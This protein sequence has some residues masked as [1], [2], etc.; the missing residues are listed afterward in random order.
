MCIRCMIEAVLIKMSI[1]QVSNSERV[2]MK[3]ALVNTEQRII[4]EVIDCGC[5]VGQDT[6][7]HIRLHVIGEG[8]NISCSS[9]SS[10]SGE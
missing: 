8:D 1:F 3:F 9:I 4:I 6:E 10:S 7:G 2:R 5:T